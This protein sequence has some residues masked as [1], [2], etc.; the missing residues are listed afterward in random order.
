MQLLYTADSMH[1]PHADKYKQET[2]AVLQVV[3]LCSCCL[4]PAAC[5][6]L[7]VSVRRFLSLVLNLASRSLQATPSASS[8]S[9]LEPDSRQNNKGTPASP[10]HQMTAATGLQHGDKQLFQTGMRVYSKNQTADTTKEVR[11]ESHI[12]S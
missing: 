4:L 8:T 7:T 5:Q 10:D 1:T 2:Q 6:V 3:L 12:T 9:S 11:P